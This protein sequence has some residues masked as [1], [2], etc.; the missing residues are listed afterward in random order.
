MN[1]VKEVVKTLIISILLAV[2]IVKITF[3]SPS[4][5]VN[6]IGLLVVV[7]VE[8]VT[9][10]II[11]KTIKGDIP[12]NDNSREG[13]VRRFSDR[14]GLA[15]SSDN[16]RTI[17]EASYYSKI[18]GEELRAFQKEYDNI[19]AW[20][21]ANEERTW[22]RVYLKA[23]NALDISPDNEEQYRIV[24]ENNYANLVKSIQEKEFANNDEV[25]RYINNKYYLSFDRNSFA[26]WKAYMIDLGYKLNN[27]ND[28][29]IDGV[30]F[31]G[32]LDELIRRYEKDDDNQ[33]DQ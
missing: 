30:G 17:V 28:G 12:I 5:M 31:Y 11:W 1:G 9:M 13:V 4:T 29:K 18:W 3:S 21:T 25:I 15:L 16:I 23:F 6:V 27:K 14:Y 33:S 26:V 2:V 7:V 20:L 22:L 32:I 8:I 24:V 19:G 10:I